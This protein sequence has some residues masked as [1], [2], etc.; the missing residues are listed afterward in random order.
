MKNDAYTLEIS[1]ED[2]RLCA[3]SISGLGNALKSMRQL[4][5]SERGVPR[6][7]AFQLPPL[8]IEDE[9]AIGFRGIHFCWFP[10][11]PV[12][13]IEKNIRL[14]AYYKFNYAV[15]ESWGMIRL[16]SHPEFCWDE[17]RAEKRSE[18]SGRTRS[19]LRIDAD[20]PAE[21]LWPCEF[22]P[23]RKR[24]THAAGPLSRIRAAL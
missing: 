5:E 22:L 8:R 13:E 15:I 9:P 24:K 12:W 10:E 17:L 3:S 16:D 14:A 6:S 11:T 20:P 23:L 18:A 2:C 21:S 4:A 1:A 19:G 7:A